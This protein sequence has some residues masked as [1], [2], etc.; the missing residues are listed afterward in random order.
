MNGLLSQIATSLFGQEKY[1]RT[2]IM[3]LS[4]TY[5][6]VVAAYTMIYDLKNSIFMSIVGKEYVPW[7]KVASMV[8]L[9]PAVLFY[10]LLVDRWRRY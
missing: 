6:F 7:A 2:K 8:V 10:S 5:L 9:I 1:E 4:L 3:L